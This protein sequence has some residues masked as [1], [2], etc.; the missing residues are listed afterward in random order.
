[1]IL[2]VDLQNNIDGMHFAFD[3][4]ADN[5]MLNHSAPL[6][7]YQLQFLTTETYSNDSH[8][9]LTVVLSQ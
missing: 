8:N 7:A 4:R 3:N 6:I 5:K 9:G 1:V 2:L